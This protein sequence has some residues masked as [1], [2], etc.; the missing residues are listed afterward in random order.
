[1]STLRRLKV[2][3]DNE[4]KDLEVSEKDAK[5][6]Y[7]ETKT[8]LLETEDLVISLKA[9]VKQ[10]EVQLNDTKEVLAYK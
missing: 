7:T 10:L 6:R 2:K 9:S 1:M 8:K 5:N 3:Y 4:I